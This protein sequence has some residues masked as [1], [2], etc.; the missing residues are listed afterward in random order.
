MRDE[1]SKQEKEIKKVVKQRVF[2]KEQEMLVEVKRE[3]INLEALKTKLTQLQLQKEHITR[4]KDEELTLIN[5][6]IDSIQTTLD[7]AVELG[8]NADA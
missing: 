1:D 3:P 6:E 7:K 2:E 8:V 4:M 5:A